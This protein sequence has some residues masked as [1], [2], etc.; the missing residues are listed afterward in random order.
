V[1]ATLGAT[2]TA[3]AVSAR[4]N[5]ADLIALAIN[6]GLPLLL[7][8]LGWLIGG[9]RER[10][11]LRDLARREALNADVL[12]TDLRAY[13]PADPAAGA[14]MVTSEVVIAADYC[15]VFLS[16]LRN[17]LGGNLRS[18]E[19][20]M[21]RARREAVLRLIEQARAR[22]FNALCCVR[23]E[24]SNVGKGMMPMV[25]VLASATAYRVP[26]PPSA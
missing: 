3:A 14:L 16:G 25:A 20:L 18:Y 26:V 12:R 21:E 5:D 4:G 17:L 8:L 23:I 15:K 11:H 9:Q 24:S 7:L 22:Q 6:L 19:T 13:G 2:L 10:A 1:I